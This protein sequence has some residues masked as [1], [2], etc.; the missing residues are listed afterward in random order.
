[1]SYFG[2]VLFF[3]LFVATKIMDAKLSFTLV[4]IIFA[5]LTAQGE[6]NM[7]NPFKDSVRQKP[8]SKCIF[9]VHC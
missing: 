5:S 7:K 8:I 6:T 9:I 3:F 4:L 2:F 1:M